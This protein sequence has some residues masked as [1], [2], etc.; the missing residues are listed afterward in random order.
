MT[1]KSRAPGHGAE[2]DGP[3]ALFAAAKQVQS[4]QAMMRIHFLDAS[5][6]LKL[7]S[8]MAATLP[9]TL[10]AW[11]LSHDMDAVVASGIWPFFSYV[12]LAVGDQPLASGRIAEFRASIQA[13]RITANDRS[14][15][16]L[17]CGTEVSVYA[18]RGGGK[19][20]DFM[21]VSSDER[22][23]AGRMRTVSNL[24][25]PMAPPDE[26]A[27][28]TLPPQ[29]QA[30]DVVACAPPPSTA[31]L[32]QAPA[33]HARAAQA[34]AH[35]HWAQ[36]HTDANQIVFSGEYLACAEDLCGALAQQAG[37]PAA[38]VRMTRG[39]LALKRPFFAGQEYWAR[40]QLRRDADGPRAVALISFHGASAPGVIDER[41][42]SAVRIDV[43]IG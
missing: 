8:L 12:D 6:R 2:N 11:R 34:E 29:M 19:A 26:R 35:A 13:G 28:R 23:W 14:D 10:D 39:Q 16:A 7:R 31:V 5:L 4:A 37:L 22:E 40:G 17:V 41:P 20:G 36:H 33:G 27:V 18:Q 43:A 1:D 24:V 15:G 42:C 9:M 25:R 38:S 21:H 30:L 3:A 32:L